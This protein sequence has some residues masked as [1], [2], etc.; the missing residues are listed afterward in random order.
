[1]S[2]HPTWARR[3]GATSLRPRGRRAGGYC[4][5]VLVVVGLAAALDVGGAGELAVDAGD[6]FD[7]ALGGEALVEAFDAEG[8]G[9]IGPGGEAARPALDAVVLGVGV[10]GGE[11]GA[12]AEQGLDGDRLGDHEAVVGP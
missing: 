1:M 4:A 6:A 12:D 10:D 8:L 7:L 9:E 5:S 2:L 11:V 3:A